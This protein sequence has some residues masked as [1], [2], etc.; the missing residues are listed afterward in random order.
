[1][2]RIVGSPH[3]SKGRS[4]SS[5]GVAIPSRVDST[6]GAT[7]A[8][9]TYRNLRVNQPKTISHCLHPTDQLLDSFG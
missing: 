2:A 5:I 8:P 1:M 4:Q 6:Y 9:A 3:Q 7:T